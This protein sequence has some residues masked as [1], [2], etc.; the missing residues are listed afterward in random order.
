MY[1]GKPGGADEFFW[2]RDDTRA[3]FAIERKW[4][5]GLKHSAGR[6]DDPVNDFQEQY[7]AIL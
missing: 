1:K 4:T 6:T 2:Q 7:S 5:H 3:P